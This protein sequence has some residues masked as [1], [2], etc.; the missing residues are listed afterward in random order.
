MTVYTDADGVSRSSGAEYANSQYDRHGGYMPESHPDYSAA[1]AAAYE[2]EAAPMA[3]PIEQLQPAPGPDYGAAQPDYAPEPYDYNEPGVDFSAPDEPVF[4]PFDETALRGVIQDGVR[5]EL[6]AY[7]PTAQE[8]EWNA[9]QADSGEAGD[10][11]TALAA[12]RDLAEN[13]PSHIAQYGLRRDGEVA[14][15]AAGLLAP[16][17]AVHADRLAT[18]AIAQ[19]MAEGASREEAGNLVAGLFP[20]LIAMSTDIAKNEASMASVRQQIASHYGLDRLR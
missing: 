20:S 19:A 9:Q 12:Q 4:D 14:Q 15:Q 2:A 13:L 1:W 18:E 10:A 17:V 3:P 6:G 5:A 8:Q 7:E 11:L 16:A